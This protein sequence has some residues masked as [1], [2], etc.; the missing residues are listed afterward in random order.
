MN[1][2]ITKQD[3]IDFENNIVKE[4][5]KGKTFGPVHLSGGNEEQLIEIFKN[6]KDEDWI[7]STHRSHYHAF[8][9]SGDE[10]WLVKEIIV[11]ANS[12]HINS[13]KYKIFTSAIVGGCAPIALGVALGI[14]LKNGKEH[15]WCFVGDMA[16]EMGGYWESLKYAQNFDLPITFVI[17]DNK[18]G[19]NTCTEKVW[20]GRTL[21][22]SP[23][24][25]RYEYTRVYPHYGI[26]E[27]VTFK[28]K[29]S[30]F[31]S[32]GGMYG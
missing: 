6:I 12:S 18:L 8:L 11:N 19:C 30:S 21:I 10:D 7:F 26:G 20:N 13:K 27:F 3:L 31:K 28:R 9:K 15:V 5:K 17:E 22:S 2:K 4:F 1:D 29:R 16:S 32:A 14:K 25:I 23:K 24:Q